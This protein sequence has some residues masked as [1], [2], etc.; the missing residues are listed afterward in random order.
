MPLNMI[1][2]ALKSVGSNMSLWF[3]NTCIYVSGN[4]IQ[5]S[6]CAIC[7]DTITCQATHAPRVCNLVLSL[8]EEGNALLAQ[9]K[10]VDLMHGHP[11]EGALDL[12][13]GAV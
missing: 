10:M 5:E 3:S 8:V 1:I 7:H 2:C 13:N 12:S 4:T 11:R 6:S 9:G